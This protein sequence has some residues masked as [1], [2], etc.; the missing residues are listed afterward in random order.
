MAD[1]SGKTIVLINR[2][3]R[4]FHVSGG[5]SLP[6]GG[7]IELLEN[8]AKSMLGYSDLVDAAKAAPALGDAIDALRSENAALKKK[9]MELEE[10]VEQSSTRYSPKLESS[11]KK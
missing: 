2:G 11:K 7:S 5:R 1:D 9:I 8:E 6:P 4:T 10:E 3:M